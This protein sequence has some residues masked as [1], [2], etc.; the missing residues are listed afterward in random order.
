MPMSWSSALRSR[1]GGTSSCAI[2]AIPTPSLP[3]SI[4][5]ST[6]RRMEYDALMRDPEPA[7]AHLAALAQ[8]RRAAARLVA[9]AETER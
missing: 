3:A 8:R 2:R 9:A 5:S 7:A 1:A 4:P 6:R